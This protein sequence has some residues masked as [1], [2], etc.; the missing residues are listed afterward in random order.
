MNI[1]AFDASLDRTYISLAGDFG[2]AQK[3]IKTNDS[4]YHSAYLI[5]ALKEILENNNIELKN[6]DLIAVNVGPGSFTGIRVG[7]TVAR[8]IAKELDLKAFG[9]N[10]F[11]IL[12]KTFENLDPAIVLD[13][14]RNQFYVK[15]KDEITLVN[16]DEIANFVN[17]KT[18]VCDASS[19]S[20][21]KN[22]ENPLLK[23]EINIINFEEEE[24][25]LSL[26]LLKLASEALLSCRDI[27]NPCG[28]CLSDRF[29]ENSSK[30][31]LWNDLKPLYIQAPPVFQ[32]N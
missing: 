5:A 30:I 11:D 29:F 21:L 7:M 32:K 10:S 31:F 3:V 12:S 23:P 8:T 1:L 28:S 27:E 19:F 18:V 22:P 15:A 16:Y 2:V 26:S 17:K 4:N 6:L 20:R 13:A 14:R 9:A 24:V 25:N